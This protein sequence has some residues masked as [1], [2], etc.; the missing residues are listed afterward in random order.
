MP[1][2][3]VPG[4]KTDTATAADKEISAEEHELRLD[5]SFMEKSAVN[6]RHVNRLKADL[7]KTPDCPVLLDLS[8]LNDLPP[9]GINL[10]AGLISECSARQ[11]DFAIEIS[12]SSIGRLFQALK[13]DQDIEI[14]TSAG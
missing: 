13:L 5:G 6:K 11:R 9:S 2:I 8:G 10:I 14:R 7:A 3:T 1:W 12:G 4:K